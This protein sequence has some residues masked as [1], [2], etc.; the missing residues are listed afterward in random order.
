MEIKL[1]LNEEEGQKLVNLIAYWGDVAQDVEVA[2]VYPSGQ[3]C[4][5]I[6]AQ[7][8]CQVP[9]PLED[10]EVVDEDG[11][12][13]GSCKIVKECDCNDGRQCGCGGV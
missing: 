7:L 4:D 9:M 10:P 6:T 5:Y 2:D 11:C 3:L 8:S 1:T 13:G 12:S